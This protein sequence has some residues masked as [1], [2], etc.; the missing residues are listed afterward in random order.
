MARR[1]R[2]QQRKPYVRRR[3]RMARPNA[4]PSYA[5]PAINIDPWIRVTLSMEDAGTGDLDCLSVTS[6]KDALAAQLNMSFAGKYL[7]LQM[8][9]VRA[10]NISGGPL[11]IS[12]YQIVDPHECSAA[13]LAIRNIE[14]YPGRNRWAYIN[15]NW[16]KPQQSIMLDSADGNVIVLA[17]KVRKSEIILFHMCVAFKICDPGNFTS[18]LQVRDIPPHTAQRPY[19]NDHHDGS[20]SMDDSYSDLGSPTRDEKSEVL[21]V[22]RS[23]RLRGIPPDR[24]RNIPGLCSC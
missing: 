12:P 2:R 9:R 1:N 20:Q 21:I 15:F 14:D 8:R 6:I 7:V 16:P 13:A 4:R 3:G 22:R 5:P 17:R 19:R 10:W 18:K 24:G 23:L 11:Y